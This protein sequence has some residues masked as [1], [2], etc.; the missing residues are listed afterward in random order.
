MF[1]RR[2]FIESIPLASIAISTSSSVVAATLQPDAPENALTTEPLIAS[3]PVVQHPRRNGFGVS[4]AVSQLATAWIEYGFEPDKLSFQAIASH[5]G[6]VHA[7]DQ[8]LH[9]RVEHP[10]PLPLDRPIFYRVI[11]QSLTYQNAYS[12]KRGEQ[13][14]TATYSLRLPADGATRVRLVCV[15]DTHEN[16]QTI[17]SLHRIVAQLEPDLLLWNG[18]T[19]ND[20][21]HGDS[22]QQITLNPAKDLSQAWASCRPLVFSCGNHDVRGERARELLEC[23]PGCPENPSL[24]YNQA[25]RLGPLAL[26]T[27]D[28]GEDKPDAH[29]VFAGTAAYEPY[30][31]RQAIWLKQVLDRSD[32][33]DAPVKIIACHIP[34]RGQ[35]GEPDGTALNAAAHYCG[36]G[37]KLWLPL[38]KEAAVTAI[39]SGHM[40]QDRFDVET[41]DMPILQF[42]GGGPNLIKPR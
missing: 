14:S 9:I 19:C 35:P 37:A 22:P 16:L 41:P 15:N 11:A 6:L 18:D 26:I 38:L 17:Q 25:L 40:H 32:I 21:D 33:K 28:T 39:L 4:I 27:L 8:A 34:L 24:P 23:L 36:F 5:H 12:L 20:F 7:S 3:P 2:Q 29:P 31:Q 13:E 1:N 42:V 30:R 10:E